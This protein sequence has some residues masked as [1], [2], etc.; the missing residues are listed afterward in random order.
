[1]P[2]L[3]DV[4]GSE[5]ANDWTLLDKDCDLA[6]A[7]TQKGALIVPLALWLSAAEELQA[8]GHS[9]GVWLDSDE[10]P[11]ALA[12][13]LDQLTLVALHF[14]KFTDGRAYSSA[15][16][17]RQHY[18]YQGELRAVGEVL[19]DQLFYMRRC[20]FTTFDLDDS[21]KLEDARQALQDFADSYQASSEQPLP[22]FRRR[23]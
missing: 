17:L 15:S 19:R 20:G 9:I 11:A 5:L 7:Q 16:I 2:K 12:A 14:P 13:T 22:L 10:Q 23:A 6:T 1:M 21:V 18:K 4:Q 3:I 8:S